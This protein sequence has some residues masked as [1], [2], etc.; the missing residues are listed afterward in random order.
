MSRNAPTDFWSR[1]RAAVRAEEE[2]RQASS[3]PN[4]DL[5]VEEAPEVQRSDADILAELGLKDPDTMEQGDDF[6]AFLKES[7]PL[8]LR[9]RALRRLW[10][11]NPVL[12]NLD[13]LVDHGEDFSNAATVQDGM[14]TAYQVGRG[15]MGHI[16]ALAR[17]AEAEHE[18]PAVAEPAA[19]AVPPEPIDEEDAEVEAV[20]APVQEEP[21]NQPVRRSPRFTFAGS[22]SEGMR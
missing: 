14:K 5:A 16:E 22:A 15:M 20:A 9:Q 8:H 18:T 10:R 13:G 2:A 7:V 11:S 17:A 19:I 4:R 12:A 1:R 21:E 3:E 6:A